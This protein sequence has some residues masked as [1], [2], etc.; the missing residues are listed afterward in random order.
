MSSNNFELYKKYKSIQNA[1][2]IKINQ[3]KLE[4]SLKKQQQIQECHKI[5]INFMESDKFKSD[6]IKYERCNLS[7]SSYLTL[8]S[9]KYIIVN[10]FDTDIIKD[11]TNILQ[12]K[13]DKYCTFTLENLLHYSHNNK[14]QLIIK[15]KFKDNLDYFDYFKEFIKNIF[16]NF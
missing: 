16:N 15:A 4:Q 12:S 3:D 13:S 1:N 7:L 8:N 10:W 6:I 14:T 5:I 11:I 2:Q 9:D